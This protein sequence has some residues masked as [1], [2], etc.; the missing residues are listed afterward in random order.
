MLMQQENEIKAKARIEKALKKLN[1]SLI[2]LENLNKLEWRVTYREEKEIK[3][4]RV[5]KEN[6]YLKTRYL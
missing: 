6:N 2:Y 3:T 1:R 5:M 4:V